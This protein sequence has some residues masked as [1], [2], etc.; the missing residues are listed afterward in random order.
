[1]PLPRTLACLPFLA[2]L[3]SAQEAAP[4]GALP[5][6]VAATSVS[7]TLAGV[8]GMDTVQKMMAAWNEAFQRYH[9]G[10]NITVTSR[11]VAPEER[12]GLGPNTDEVFSPTYQ[13]YEDKYGYEPF[14]IRIV[15]APRGLKSHVSAIGVYVNP[16]NPIGKLSLAELDAMFSEERRRGYPA[17]LV[18]WGQLGLTGEWADRPVHLYGFYWRDDVTASF[19]R[20][21][22]DDAPFKASYQVPGGDMSRRTPKVAAA[23]MAAVA[24]DPGGI[25]FANFSY[26]TPQVKALALSDRH[27]VVG[28]PTERDV[29]SGRYP[30]ERYLYFYVNRVPG[31]PL[32]PL[33]KEFLTFVLSREG[34][35]LV[36]KDHYLPLTPAIDA[37]ERAK[38][39]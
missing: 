1:M 19:R 15:M 39:E 5:P 28:Q 31:R 3:L 2:G 16:A 17:D 32:D 13:P 38:L 12:I 27:G 34:Q 36:A 26:Q 24:A 7:G 35:A 21:V 33:V 37:E 29:A 4:S 8:T 30:L 25:G 22:M 10:A 20:L 6:Y 11:D 18:T 9:P 23:I 14:R